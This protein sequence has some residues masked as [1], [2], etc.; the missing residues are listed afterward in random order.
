ME[1]T[2]ASLTLAF[3]LI[4]LMR[5]DNFDYIYRGLF[6]K[7]ITENILNLS[8]AK[9][10]ITDENT[11][12]LNKHVYL[13]MVECLQNITRHQE[14]PSAENV[15]D[16]ALFMIQ[17][18]EDRYMITTGNLISNSN[19]SKLKEDLDKVNGLD[20]RELKAY[21]KHMLKTGIIS[22]KGGAGLGL[23]SMARKS[24][25][26][27]SYAFSEVS[28]QLSYFYFRAEVLFDPQDTIERK[29]ESFERIIKIHKILNDE[30]ILLNFNGTFNKTNIINLLPIIETQINESINIKNRVLQVMIDM[31]Q[32]IVNYSVPP[33][34]EKLGLHLEGN[35]GIFYLSQNR[36]DFILTAGN[37]MNNNHIP[38]LKRKLDFVNKLTYEKLIT[39]HDRLF[40]YFSD[41]E[42]TKPDLSIIEMRL[43]SKHSLEYK[44]DKVDNEHSFFT[45]QAII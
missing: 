20:V 26:K 34:I 30:N 17:Q 4:S 35:P 24:R 10:H 8:E 22:H 37:Y 25:S 36:H 19:I 42:I 15:E 44:F 6:T 7:S 29:D 2:N 38:I 13:V 12:V 23:I 41:N 16:T 28:D 45:I 40:D 21:Y 1:T 33:H 43:K 31:L 5:D 3:Q 11:S 27:L 39:F 9:L 14:K 32:N 18:K